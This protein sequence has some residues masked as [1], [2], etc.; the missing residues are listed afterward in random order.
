MTNMIKRILFFTIGFISVSLFAQKNDS[1]V[2]FLFMGDIMQHD[3]QFIPEFDS[4]SNKYDYSGYYKYVS[5]IIKQ[6]DVAVANLE[7]TL[8]GKPYSGY[9]QFSAPD[10]LAVYSKQAGIDYMTTANN[11]SNDK[12]KKGVL[13][14]IKMLDSLEINHLGTYINDSLRKATYPYVIQKNGI[15]VALLNYT[16]GT[17]GIPDKAP[18]IVNR[19]D[20]KIIL[21][22]IKAAKAKNVDKI[23]VVAHWGKEY[24]TH[25]DDYQKNIGNFLLKNGVDIVV[26]GH[27]HYIQP[28]EYYK[29]GTYGSVKD[30]RLIAWSLGNFVS[31]QYARRKDGGCML[32][33][34]LVLQADGHVKIKNQG[35]Y[36]TWVWAKAIDGNMK[37][38][39]ICPVSEF[40]QTDKI[41]LLTPSR[42]TKINTFKADSE[43]LFNADNK[44]VPQYI[45]NSVSN[46][47]EL[48][49]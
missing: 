21:E 26:G 49:K 37:K 27:P 3:R 18:T 42:K 25:P 8:A 34:D 17:N 32:Q 47:W 1:S 7:V 30:E 36:L 11:H 19:I 41:D 40:V 20:K 6:A 29:E 10:E 38:H 9:P 16:Y 46:T 14:T 44:L 23:I 22:D 13:R 5:P 24:Q 48:E 2:T 4:A 15:K 33:F 39:L 35:Y 45:F 31:G 28:M 12:G 43:A